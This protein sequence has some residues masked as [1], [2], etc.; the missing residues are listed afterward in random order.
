MKT[1]VIGLLFLGFTNLMIA[2]NDLALLATP[3]PTNHSE[4]IKMVKNMDYLTTMNDF[5][6]SKKVLKL[7]DLVANYD[8]K[9]H[10]VYNSKSAT[11]YT[12][13]FKEG[14]NNLLA[15]YDKNGTLLKCHEQYQNIK[16]PFVLSSEI[17]KAN[18]GYSLNEVYC[19]IQY[20]KDVNTEIKYRVVLKNGRK[21][22]TVLLDL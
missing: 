3:N 8:I 21:T 5:D 11:T 10:N 9:A 1:Y 12:V 13:N 14:K 16:L 7:Q 22:K 4:T 20:N 15:V 18:P 2:Q 17:I 6:I 19:N